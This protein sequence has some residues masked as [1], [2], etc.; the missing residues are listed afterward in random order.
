MKKFLVILAVT[1]GL[2]GQTATV[3]TLADALGT[4][5]TPDGYYNLAASTANSNQGGFRITVSSFIVGGNHK[6]MFSTDGGSTYQSL[7]SY[8]SGGVAGNSGSSFNIDVTQL[9]INDDINPSEGTVIVWRV[10][11][12]DASFG[13]LVNVTPTANGGGYQGSGDDF[14]YDVTPPTV[15]SISDAY[16]KQGQTTDLTGSGFTTGGNAT[17]VK[18]GSNSLSYTV[19]SNTQITI[20][21]GTGDYTGTVTVTDAAGNTSTTTSVSY[22]L[23]NTAP[24]VSSVSADAI[25]QNGTADIT[26]TGFSDTPASPIASVKINGTVPTGLNFNVASDTKITITAGSGEVGYSA[27]TVTDEAGNTSTATTVKIAIDNT[28]PTISSV[29]PSIG[30]QGTNITIT[31]TGFT[32]TG[33]STDPTITI[34]GSSTSSLSITVNSISAT[35]ITL[36]CGSSEVSNGS[37]V[38]TDVAGNASGSSSKLTI[39]NTKPT[40]SSVGTRYIKNGI[41]SIITGTGFTDNGNA[42]DVKIGGT[43]VSSYSIDRNTQITITGGSPEFTDQNVTVV[44]AA[45]NESTD[46]GKLIT[47]DNTAP[48]VTSLG[49]SDPDIIKSGSTITINGSGFN[50]GSPIQSGGVTVGG[51]VP[52]NMSFTVNN[53]NTITITAGSGE[54]NGNVVVTDASGNASTATGKTLIID[55]TAPVISSIS[56]ETSSQTVLKSSQSAVLSGSGFNNT[57]VSGSDATVKLGD[58]DF[59]TYGTV[60]VDNNGQI[61]LTVTSSTANVSGNLKVTDFAGNVTTFSGNTFYIDN[62][63]PTISSVSPPVIKSGQTATVTGTGFLTG[64]LKST[65]TVGGGTPTGMNYTVD[66]NTQITITAGSGEISDGQIVIT[67][68]AGNVSTD[69]IRLTIDNTNPIVTSISVSSIKNGS[70]TVITGTGFF[71]TLNSVSDGT[72]VTVTVGGQSPAGMSITVNSDTQITLTAGSGEVTEG[73]VV[74]TD[75]AGN[76]SQE[77]GKLLTIDNTPPTISSISVGSIK[78]GASTVITGSGFTVGGNPSSVK[79]GGSV[80]TGMD[81]SSVSNTSITITAG[82]GEVAD[83][84]VVVTDAAGNASTSSIYLTIDNT[85]PTV[86]SIGTSVIASGQT[87][88]ITGSGFLNS[89]PSSG[90]TIKVKT[91]NVGGSVP[92]GLTFTGGSDTKITVTAG[93]GEITNGNVTVVDS[94]GNESTDVNKLLTIDNTAPTIS[95]IS[96]RWIRNGETTVL[97]GSGFST[98]GDA[99][100]ITIGGKNL[101]TAVSA[102]GLGGSFTVDSDTKITITGGAGEVTR[103]E[104]VVYDVVGNASTGFK[105]LSIDNT[106]PGVPSI[107]LN[108]SWDTGFFNVDNISNR[109]NPGFRLSGGT[110]GDSALIKFGTTPV[111]GKHVTSSGIFYLYWLDKDANNPNYSKLNTAPSSITTGAGTYTFYATLID[112]AGNESAADSVIYIFDNVAPSTPAVDGISMSSTLDESTTDK[113]TND[114]TPSFRISNVTVGN[115]LTVYHGVDPSNYA[116]VS[117]DKDTIDAD[118][119]TFSLVSGLDDGTKH[120]LYVT[121]TDTAGNAATSTSFNDFTIDTAVPTCSLAYGKNP[122]R[123]EDNTVTITAIFSEK[124]NT[125]VKP[126]L[127]VDFPDTTADIIDTTMSATTDDSLWTFT[128]GLIDGVTGNVKV[129]VDGTDKAGNALNVQVTKDTT[130]LFLDNTNPADFT[131]GTVTTLRDRQ[132]TGWINSYTDSI[133]IEVPVDASDSTLLYGGDVKIQANIQS[134]MSDNWVT[135][136]TPT[137]DRDSIV[138]RGTNIVFYRPVNKLVSSLGSNLAQGDEIRFR[139]VINDKVGNTTNGTPSSSILKYDIVKPDTSHFIGGNIFTTSRDTIFST[140]TLTATW[141]NFTDPNASTASGIAR[142]EYAL[143]EDTIKAINNFKDWTS[144][145]LDTTIEIIKALTHNTWYTLSLRAVDSAGN[146][147]DTLTSS[148]VLRYNSRPSIIQIDSTTVD[149]DVLYTDLVQVND[150]DLNTLL[151]D[152]FSYELKT[153]MLLTNGDTALIDTMNASITGE[154]KITFTPTKWDTANYIFRVI[155]TDKWSLKD[156]MDYKVLVLPVNDAPIINLSSVGKLEFLEGANS[157][158]IN[159]T[160]YSFDEDNDTTSLKWSAR[161]LSTLPDLPGYP[162]GRIDFDPTHPPATVRAVRKSLQEQYPSARI[163]QGINAQTG[164]LYL[165]LDAA[166]DKLKVNLPKT[167]DSTFASIAPVDTNYYSTSDLQVEFTVI[168]PGNLEG[169]DTITFSITPIND[170]PKWTGLKDTTVVENDSIYLDFANYLSDV[171]DS[172]LTITIQPLTFGS[173]MTVKPSKTYSTTTNGVAFTST[174]KNDT[175]KFKPAQ[176]WFGPT[177]PWKLSSSDSSLIQISAADSDTTVVDSFVVRVQRVPRPEIRMYVVQNNAFTNF[178]EVFIVDSVGKTTDLTLEIQSKQVPLD[179]VAA[180]TYVGHHQFSETQGNYIFEVR[181]TGVV[182]DTIVSNTVGLAV[183]RVFASWTGA[184]PDGRFR[185]TGSTGTVEYD[186]TVLIID[187]TMF[188]PYFS[189][190]ASYL[191]GNDI[192]GFKR[193]VEV[194][195]PSRESEIAIYE[196]TTGMGWVELPSIT[197][198]GRAKA[199]TD[200]MGYFRLGPKTLIVPGMTSLHQNYPNPFNPVTTIVFDLGFVDG[201]YQRV[202]LAV[203]NILGQNVKTLV[204]D[205]KGIGRYTVRWNGKDE[206]GVDVASGIYFVHLMTDRGRSQTK[207][208]MLIR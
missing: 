35:S 18:A 63:E 136:N 127:S 21:G 200:K 103:G 53:D 110:A 13:S 123:F 118:P 153:N 45:G 36:T 93:S 121:H 96:D 201:P 60:S 76:S 183:A 23:D 46:T 120:D 138:E 145:S 165:T 182:G 104:I 95:S 185:V 147:S 129:T 68:P 97:T 28:A 12:Y 163:Y 38:V 184:S 198:N 94:A 58:T 15:S 171:D 143:Q 144:V 139:A 203:Y 140:D 54:A 44:D 206:N 1:A 2:W 66:S 128:L 199:Y 90:G 194:S 133:K 86:T 7:S 3:Q 175:V 149:E 5:D 205:E 88:V 47:V 124:M 39:D 119:F 31:G 126:T 41:T 72:G 84:Q 79:V 80:P 34:G 49:S 52:T 141:I 29:S 59:T 135:V 130:A 164:G 42:T 43:S 125:R 77:T 19:N 160:A 107:T 132:V 91:V 186:Q 89:T 10:Q 78:S 159:L 181:A 196:R 168:D 62:T 170:P 73:N 113:I 98:N 17:A 48:V 191:L 64:T 102:G 154:G 137:S 117:I 22:T 111:I 24:V 32:T 85:A 26:G 75:R 4:S 188:E 6:V 161:I 37:V 87:S 65:L 16:I 189:D 61:T 179:T 115:L 40:V 101:A 11:S 112:S 134:K 207:K 67:D 33:I 74:V 81:T 106:A 51:S 167:G 195:L 169:K 83:G 71:T 55:N 108:P 122:V 162:S 190:R 202:Q 204:N 27:I 30:K 174:S 92:T 192:Y 99:S 20:T 8:G 131:T 25:K 158:T 156:T 187:S 82:T 172:L 152:S 142:Y 197:E 176:L 173:N 70:T 100:K 105:E 109:D 193:P 57:G 9:M 155:V 114:N 208:I 56:P 180:Y 177:G 146:F 69:D 50:S 116:Q 166:G 148:P 178:Y 14:F 150:L 157:D 151:G